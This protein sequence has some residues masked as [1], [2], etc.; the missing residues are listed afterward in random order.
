M[1]F[2]IIVAAGTGSRMNSDLPK[3]FLNLN[4]LPVIMHTINRFFH[5]ATISEVILVI[6]ETM[7]SFWNELCLK[8]QFSL[9]IH[10]TFGGNTRFESVKNGIEYIQ[11]NFDIGPK[12][13]IAVHDGARPIVPDTL[14]NRAFE[15]AY[16]HQ[17]I[18]LAQKSIESVRL[19]ASLSNKACDR[20]QVWL[21]QT[22]Q[23]FHG[24]LLLQAYQQNE[25]PLFTD[26]A[27]VIEKMGKHI[28]MI[29]GDSKNIKITHPQD[30]QIA[31]FYLSL[32]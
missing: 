22:P 19:G 18:V 31:Q 6:S 28:T 25:D 23:V 9:P 21:I 15:G 17:A 12:D 29:E 1:N 8:H 14:I 3:Q 24:E 7:E 20:D 26:D 4:G 11:Q 5:S 27:S 16:T 10:I 30:L 32:I 2:V 13:Y